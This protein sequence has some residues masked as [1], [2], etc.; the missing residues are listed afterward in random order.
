MFHHNNSIL[1][2]WLKFFPC[3]LFCTIVTISCYTISPNITVFASPPTT[4][5]KKESVS[6]EDNQRKLLVNFKLKKVTKYVGFIVNRRVIVS[7]R[8]CGYAFSDL[9]NSNTTEK[10]IPYCDGHEL[11]IRENKVRITRKESSI[12]IVRLL[13]NLFLIITIISITNIICN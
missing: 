11:K 9:Q 6:V 1:M 8:S 7:T 2:N 3:I 13:I 5:K 4:G 12:M 10:M